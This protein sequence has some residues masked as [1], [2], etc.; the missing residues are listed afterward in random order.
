MPPSN[1]VSEDERT[2]EFATLSPMQQLVMEVLASRYR[3][4]H[5]IWTFTNSNALAKAF[6]ALRERG[7]IETMSG[8]I[9]HTVRAMLTAKGRDLVLDPYYVPPILEKRERGD[10]CPNCDDLGDHPHGPCSHWYG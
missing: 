8:V 7:Y 4:G 10:E 9:Q 3:L 2:V 1:A 6:K 5:E